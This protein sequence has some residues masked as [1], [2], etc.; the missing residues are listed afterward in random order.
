M[1]FL[2]AFF[3]RRGAGGLRDYLVHVYGLW[4]S[5]SWE[6]LF[7]CPGMNLPIPTNMLSEGL[8]C[9]YVGVLF[10]SAAH[11]WLLHI[12]GHDSYFSLHECGNCLHWLHLD[13]GWRRIGTARNYIREGVKISSIYS[14]LLASRLEHSVIALVQLKERKANR[15]ALEVR[16]DWSQWPLPS[17]RWI[18]L[19]AVA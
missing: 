6:L 5:I 17:W 7:S 10:F 11:L 3:G 18:L 4:L 12:L 13:F 16:A 15:N 9:L 1:L 8:E 14:V 2:A 19:E